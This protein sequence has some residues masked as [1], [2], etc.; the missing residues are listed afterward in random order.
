MRER[1]HIFGASGAGTSTLGR[2]LAQT[3]GLTFFDTD[4]FFWEA[5]DPPYQRA[6]ERGY[7]QQLLTKALSTTRRWVLAGSLCG[8]GDV[9]IPL[10]DLAV[11]VVTDSDIRLQRLRTREQEAF[12]ERI[13]PGGDMHN[14]HKSLLEWAARYDEGHPPERTRQLHE[15]WLTGLECPLVRADGAR[16]VKELCKEVSAAMAATR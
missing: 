12:G 8:W 11:F 6:R 1:I 2:E 5:T 16:P 9:A 4:D 13:S 10:F 15:E 7:R 3:H 14:Q